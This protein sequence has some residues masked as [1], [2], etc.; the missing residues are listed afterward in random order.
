MVSNIVYYLLVLTWRLIYF[1]KRGNIRKGCVGI[2]DWGIFVYFVLGL[3]ENSMQKLSA[4]WFLFGYKRNSKS[5]IYLHSLIIEFLWFATY[6][7]NSRKRY[8]LRLLSK[9]FGKSTPSLLGVN[10]LLPSLIPL[11]GILLA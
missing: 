3:Q 6:G 1:W 7:S 8:T 5:F 9:C 2:E 10:S 4:F 11:D